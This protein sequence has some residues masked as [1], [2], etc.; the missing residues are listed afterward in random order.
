MQT[1]PEVD[2]AIS[3]LRQMNGKSVTLSS[4]DAEWLMAEIDGG[5][6]AFGVVVQKKRELEQKVQQMQRTITDLSR[7]YQDSVKRPN[8]GALGK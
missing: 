2:Q 1:V 4:Q 7:M 3:R 6:E 5:R 8:S